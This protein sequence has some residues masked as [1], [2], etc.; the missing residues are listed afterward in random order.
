MAVRM[1]E[2]SGGGGEGRGSRRRPTLY[3]ISYRWHRE[4]P[5]A[6]MCGAEWRRTGATPTC[7]CLCV[8]L[9]TYFLWRPHVRRRSSSL[10][11]PLLLPSVD[12]ASLCEYVPCS[13]TFTTYTSIVRRGD[14]GAGRRFA[15]NK[16]A[17]LQK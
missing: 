12:F 4:S 15:R 7:I 10:Y 13:T 17:C 6:M 9:S 5:R 8:T 11:S 16:P 1:T 3:I 2:K 14:A